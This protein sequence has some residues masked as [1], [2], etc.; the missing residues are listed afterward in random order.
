M[1]TE[2]ELLEEF[3][4]EV[5]EAYY[6]VIMDNLPLSKEFVLEYIE[7]EL[8]KRREKTLVRKKEYD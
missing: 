6:N 4:E 8:E 1:N 7:K 3:E 2:D 5:K